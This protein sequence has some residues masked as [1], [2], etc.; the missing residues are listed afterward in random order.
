MIKVSAVVCASTGLTVLL[1][2]LGHFP[3][4]RSVLPGAVE[5]KANTALGLLAAGVSLWLVTYPASVRWRFTGQALAL[6]VC[7]LGLATA[8][9]YLFGWQL[10]IDEALFADSAG[11]FN[12]VRGRM[13]PYAAMSFAAIGVA[14]LL[15]PTARQRGLAYAAA[16]TTLMLGLL[17]VVGYAWNARELTTD[18]VLPPLALNTAVAFIFLGGGTLMAIRVVFLRQVARQPGMTTMEAKILAGFLVS[19]VLL[20]VAGGFTYKATTVFTSSAEL[21]AHTQQVRAALGRLYGD[22]SD[23]GLAQRNYLITGQPGQL[24]QYQGLAGKIKRQIRQIENLVSDNAEQLQNLQPLGPLVDRALALMD[25]DIRTYQT[26]GFEAVKKQLMSGE[27]LTTMRSIVWVITFMENEEQALLLKRQAASALFQRDMLVSMLLTLLVATGLFAI[28]FYE[29]R[30]EIRA[31]QVA[32]KALL[33]A[34]DAA[35]GAR[36]EADAASH[37]KSA[38]LATMS[39]EIRTPMNGVL[40]MLELLSLTRLDGSQHATLK[41]I[42]ESGRT[43]MRI[44]DDILD[45]SKIEA[46][47]LA[48]YPEATS[49]ADLVEDLRNTYSSNASSKGL[50]INCQVDPGLS[51]ALLVDPVRLRQILNNLVGN[52]IKFTA[53]GHIDIKVELMERSHGAER[54]RFSVQDTGIGISEAHQK[55][56]FQPFAQAE[57]NTARRYGG[58]GLGLSISRRL[59][60]LMGGAIELSSKPGQGTTMT[61]ELTLPVGDPSMLAAREHPSAAASAMPAHGQHRAAPSVAQAESEGTLVLLADDH[62]TN[63]L[64]L[65][66]QINLLGY[67]AESAKDGA[68]ALKMWKSGRFALLVTDCNMPEM[69][70]YELARA[71]RKLEADSGAGRRCPIIACTANALHGEAANCLEAGMDDYIVKPVELKSL[72]AKLE[73]WLPLPAD[74]PQPPARPAGDAPAALPI[75]HAALAK[76]SSGNAA[77]EREIF[78]EFQRAN[79]GDSA[80][81]QQAVDDRDA[82]EVKRLAHLIKGASAMICAGTLAGLCERIERANN[83]G[84]WSTLAACM[85]EFHHEVRSLNAY[86]ATLRQPADSLP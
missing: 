83:G 25:E 2:W 22:V 18:A 73:H 70:G 42:R 41:V 19:M 71:V 23:A 37:A 29:I 64:L 77:M 13:S 35:D 51:P 56:L 6:A 72:L 36:R 59:A 14:L 21:V 32:D 62:P 69:D 49:L 20:T 50:P 17:S 85:V 53:S 8:S 86:F 39:H 66:R 60:G 15:L 82:A 80:H 40:G 34:R 84:D 44:I 33:A 28:L 27:S 46:H 9:Q 12:A 68:E 43:L 55:Q 30:R 48:V 52:A 74:A 61:L 11:V 16:A 4:L 10:G 7:A 63:R 38:F 26:R 79:D 81:L 58:T 65:M 67:A 57:L 5:M 31:R 3:L 45:F 47:K 76:M 1:G 54:V 78:S 24:A 75:N